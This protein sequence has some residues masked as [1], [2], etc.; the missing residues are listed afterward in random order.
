[1]Q[2]AV[3]PGVGAMA[4]LIGLDADAVD[5]L[6][7]EAAAGQ[8]CA[9]ANHNGAGQIV[10]AGH[11]AAVERAVALAKA[12]GARRAVMLHVSAPFH[13]PLMAPAAEKLAA[14]LAR[15]TVRD[16]RVPVVANVDAE[17]TRSGARARELLVRQVTAPVRWEESVQR[18]AADGVDSAYELGSGKVLAGLVKRIAPTLRVTTIGEPHEVRAFIEGQLM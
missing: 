3:P 10:I 4:A 11:T 15:V 14:A 6:C 8:V 1:M 16:P 2:E 5:A 17:P 9:A 12:R 13:C 18:L 7:A